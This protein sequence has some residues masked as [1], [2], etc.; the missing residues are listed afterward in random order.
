MSLARLDPNFLIALNK[1]QILNRK[2]PKMAGIEAVKFSKDRFIR[3][4]WVD[5]NSQA[6]DKR[7]RS[8]KWYSDEQKNQA[9]RGSLMVKSGRLKRSIRVTNVTAN[10]VTIGTDVPYAQIHNEGGTI[11][12]TVSIKSF[13]RTRK[14]RNE[15]VKAHNRKR[16]I[17]M[18]KRQFMGESSMLLYRIERMLQLEMLKIIR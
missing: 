16:I 9:K 2:F 6:W 3:K 5:Q 10:S 17:N 18:P 8:P 11:N 12:H 13:T 7:K 14:G 4:N 15:T 1:L